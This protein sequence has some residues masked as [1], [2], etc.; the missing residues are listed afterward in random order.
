LSTG[1]VRCNGCEQRREILTIGALLEVCELFLG[2]FALRLAHGGVRERAVGCGTGNIIYR[3]EAV[4]RSYLV[5][6]G[7]PR[8]PVSAAMRH[9]K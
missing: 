9:P 8:G 6:V 7:Q 5:P 2:E 4:L 1:D 3:D